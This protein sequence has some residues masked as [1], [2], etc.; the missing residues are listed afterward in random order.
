M[1]PAN[2]RFVYGVVPIREIEVNDATDIVSNLFDYSL[3]GEV[4]IEIGIDYNG[5][6]ILAAPDAEP[7]NNYECDGW[8]VDWN[9][10]ALPEAGLY[11]IRATMTNEAGYTGTDT[12]QVY[13]DPTPPQPII[14]EPLDG[15]IV[16]GIVDL[17]ESTSG[18]NI[19]YNR[20]EYQSKPSY[21]V[22]G[23]TEK[24]QHDFGGAL[25]GVY[26]VPTS[27][28]SCLDYWADNG[29]P[30]LKPGSQSQL[31][32][33]LADYMKTT[34]DGT[35]SDNFE[36]GLRKYIEDCGYGCNNP[37][38]MWVVRH[39]NPGYDDYRR[40]LEANREDVL[41]WVKGDG[42]DHAM[43]GNSVSNTMNADGTYD[44]DF[45]DPWTGT[46][47]NTTMTPD[48]RIWYNGKLCEILFMLTV[49]PKNDTD[50]WYEIDTVYDPDDGWHAQ[51]NTTG[52]ENG[53]YWIRATMDDGVNE[54]NDFIV[55][56]VESEAGTCGDVD[57]LPGV[58]TNDGRQIFMYLLHGPEEYP[59]A[60]IWAADCDGLCDGITTND[61]RQIFMHLLYGADAYPLVCC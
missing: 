42:I 48:G 5:C 36:D 3:D 38:G 34:A 59:L 60:D 55:V 13:V 52:L 51:W 61:G 49:S 43:T 41:I 50:E 23:V 32:E 44:V 47:I 56:R 8:R 37:D 18:D 30:D 25:G 26:C 20:W 10:S 17:R 21:Y 15:A 45:M 29:F 6:D 7:M 11:Y 28:A 57:G 54:L 14:D 46:I 24:D 39:D 58:T 16:S 31:V 53:Y 33:A 12:I 9:T 35:K 27:S 19:I 4:W 40:E 2:G 1:D 22:K